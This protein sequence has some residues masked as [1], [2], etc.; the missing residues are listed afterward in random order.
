M[1]SVYSYAMN[2][3]QPGSYRAWALMN[4]PD[5]RNSDDDLQEL[6]DALSQEEIDEINAEQD[7]KYDPEPTPRWPKGA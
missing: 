5:E 1:Y 7:G 3:I 4:W 6:S 2:D